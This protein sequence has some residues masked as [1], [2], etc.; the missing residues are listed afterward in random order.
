M[1]GVSSNVRRHTR[2]RP[3][4]RTLNLLERARYSLGLAIP[5]GAAIALVLLLSS[6]DGVDLLPKSMIDWVFSLWHPVAAY[7][8]S[9]ALAP[10]ARKHVA[11]ETSCDGSQRRVPFERFFNDPRY[12]IAGHKYW[13]TGRVLFAVV[14]ISLTMLPL[15]LNLIFY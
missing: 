11:D 2:P 4:S 9:F 1:L 12:R 10:L 3:S 15:A 8:V 5:L 7:L 14:A 6:A 13:T